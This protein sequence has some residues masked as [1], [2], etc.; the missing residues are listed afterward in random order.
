M[1][2]KYKVFEAITKAGTRIELR[3]P[4]AKVTE[5]TAQIYAYHWERCS[6]E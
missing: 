5:R 4:S 6:T 1:A 3:A 2:V